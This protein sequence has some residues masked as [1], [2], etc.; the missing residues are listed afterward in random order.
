MLLYCG[1]GCSSSTIRFNVFP[2]GNAVAV[3]CSWKM[4]GCDDYT[5]PNTLQLSAT[6]L[7]Q[8]LLWISLFYVRW[9]LLYSGLLGGFWAA[10]GFYWYVRWDSESLIRTLHNH[11]TSSYY[12][13]LEGLWFMWATQ[14]NHLPMPVDVDHHDSWSAM[15]VSGA[16]SS[17]QFLKIMLRQLTG[18]CNVESSWFADW[19]LGHLDFQIEHQWV[20]PCTQI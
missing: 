9:H 11:T 8:N 14:I 2:F 13:A 16:K 5:W 15:Q 12:R 18:T 1:R 17:D 7:L 10:I 6:F 4:E 3:S 20:I 19:F